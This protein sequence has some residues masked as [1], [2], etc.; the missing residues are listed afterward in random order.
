[1]TRHLL[2]PAF[3]GLLAL[4]GMGVAVTSCSRAAEEHK[5]LYHCPMHPTYV[6]DR[7]GDCP[8]CGMKLVP[9]E[10]DKGPQPSSGP[11][12]PGPDRAA[13]GKYVCPMEECGTV[14][15]E[16]GHCPKCGMELVPVAPKPL[17]AG[18][19]A[20]AGTPPDLAEV[21]LS[22]EGIRVLGVRTVAASRGRLQ[23]T[24]RAV[25]HVTADETRIHRVHTKIG[26]YVERLHVNQTGQVVRKGQPLL[27]LY[28]PELLASQEEYLRALDAARRFADSSL[29]EVR[30]GGKALLDA[31]R[32]RLEL[33]DV[34]SSFLKKL[35]K[36]G[37]PQRTVTLLAPASGVV[38][39]KGVF[40]GQR[41]EP[42]TEV[43]TVT[44]LSRI[45]IEADLYEDEARGLALGQGATAT[46]SYDATVRLEGR[47]SFI[48]PTLNPETRTVRVRLEFAN[49]DGRLRPGD[50]ANV[51][52]PLQSADGV[53]IPDTAIMDTGEREIVF[54]EAEK[55]RFV[56]RRVVVGLRHGGQAL[57]L[58]GLA[59]GERVATAATF[60]LD[61]ESRIR[62]AVQGGTPTANPPVPAGH[63]GHAR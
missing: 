24:V 10:S 20:R 35:D 37:Q 58:E 19:H 15:D 41:I 60:L 48:Q 28:S 4:G 63:E 46:L 18:A 29:P 33:Y 26:G 11:V 49:P 23:R 3:L 44:D 43:M 45:W 47:V 21:P 56:P 39:L 14:S 31:A 59:E 17:A 16:P 40:E 1:M 54:V 2:V 6:S 32:R 36:T 25:G 30:E 9:V 22:R 7:P 12:E 34:P 61:S 57:I 27:D 55:Q 38:T 50:F 42:A 53:L 5:R 8:I 13:L 52:I 62:S 51:D